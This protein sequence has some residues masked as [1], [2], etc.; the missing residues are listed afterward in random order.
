MLQLFS[1]AASH[2][3]ETGKKVLCMVTFVLY[4]L[5]FLSIDRQDWDHRKVERKSKHLK[6]ERERKKTGTKVRETRQG[7]ARYGKAVRFSLQ[8]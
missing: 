8:L 5:I 6:R 7:K 3:A 4:T 1:S 2:R